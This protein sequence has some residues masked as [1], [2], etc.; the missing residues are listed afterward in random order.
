MVQ[1]N[2]N[3]LIISNDTILRKLVQFLCFS[4]NIDV[5]HFVLH[6][7]LLVFYIGLYYVM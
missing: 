1:Y 2:V 6:C 5:F 7:V 4:E 3:I